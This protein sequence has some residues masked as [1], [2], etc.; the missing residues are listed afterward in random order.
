MSPLQTGQPGLG[1]VQLTAKGSRGP[2]HTS[3]RLAQLHP[4]PGHSPAWAFQG[5]HPMGAPVRPHCSPGFAP[6]PRR[7]T[8]APWSS[9]V[10]AAGNALLAFLEGTRKQVKELGQAGE[11][12]V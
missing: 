10:L 2:Q 4:L 5:Q 8:Q 9:K 7:K 6:E 12:G 11:P 1:S 3:S